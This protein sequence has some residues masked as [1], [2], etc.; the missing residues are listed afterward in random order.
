M[1][2]FFVMVRNLSRWEGWGGCGVRVI[3]KGFLS[4]IVELGCLVIEF[5]SGERFDYK[6]WYC[7]INLLVY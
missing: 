2:F 6:F 5:Y 4:F 1:Y 3:S 7:E